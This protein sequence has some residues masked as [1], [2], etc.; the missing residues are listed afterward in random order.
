MYYWIKYN[1]VVITNH[2]YYGRL[3]RKMCVAFLL[4]SNINIA[5]VSL[6]RFSERV[7]KIRILLN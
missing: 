3:V 7:K 1:E 4:L 6:Q 5:E 2:K